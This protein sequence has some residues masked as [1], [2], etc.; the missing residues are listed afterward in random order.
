MYSGAYGCGPGTGIGCNAGK[1]ASQTLQ[2][3]T[4]GALPQFTTLSDAAARPLERPAFTGLP[5]YDPVLHQNTQTFSTSWAGM[6][7][8]L[9]APYLIQW[10]FSVQRELARNLVLEVRYAGNQ[11]HRQWRTFDLNEV[12]IFE[13]GFLTEFNNAKGNLDINRAA[14][15]G[16]TFQYNGLAG[17]SPLPIFSSAFGARGTV[18]AIAAG[19]GYASTGFINNLDNGAAGSLAASLM[20]QNYFCRMMGSSFAPCLRNGIAPAGQSY[21]APGAGYPINMFHL[22]PYTT[23]MNFVDDAGW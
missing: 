23:T 8:D 15:R 7:P 20:G 14:G 6:K 19:S 4:S 2:A 21:N 11:T 9:V 3:G 17:Q 13:N 10:N 18:P 22:N 12:N 1:Q 5:S 16:N